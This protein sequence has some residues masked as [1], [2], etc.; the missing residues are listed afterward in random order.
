VKF[1]CRRF[2]MDIYS[3][4]GESHLQIAL[5]WGGKLIKHEWELRVSKRPFRFR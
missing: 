5:T 4:L 2:G 1:K 3:V